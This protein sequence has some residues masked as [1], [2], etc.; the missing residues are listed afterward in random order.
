[1]DNHGYSITTTW[2]GNTGSGTAAYDTY[3][4]SHEFGSPGK[5]TIPGSSSPAYRGDDTRYN[6]EEMLLGAVSACHML[7]YLHLCTD[8]GVVVTSY[9]D[10]ATG[11]LNM[12]PSGS[13]EFKSITLNPKIE[14]AEGSSVELAR[15]LHDD[16]GR[17]CFIA[18]SL[19]CSIGYRPQIS[20]TN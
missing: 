14:L 6:P 7:W 8:N 15:S 4:R 9:T 12:N 11:E 16:A 10:N 13:G 19:K 20:V 17:M 18:R 2:T 3:E 5:P 1:M